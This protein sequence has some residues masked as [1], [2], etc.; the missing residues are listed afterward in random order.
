M[1]TFIYLVLAAMASLYVLAGMGSLGNAIS[2]VHGGPAFLAA[3]I[4]LFFAAVI[5]ILLFGPYTI[6]AGA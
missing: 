4:Q 3:A 5:C 6:V 2:E 1:V